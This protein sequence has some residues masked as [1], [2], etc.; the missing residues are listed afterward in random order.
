MKNKLFFIWLLLLSGLTMGTVVA[1]PA[2]STAYPVTQLDPRLHVE[3]Y[4]EK[5]DVV[6]GGFSQDFRMVFRNN[7]KDKLRV[8][9]E[10]YADLVCGQRV[11]NDWLKN[12]GYTMAPGELVNPTW[13]HKDFG[14]MRIHAD[15]YCP[16]ETWKKVGKDRHNSDLYNVISKLGYRIIKIENLS[17]SERAK[18]VERKKLEEER[19]AEA[20]RKAAEK[21]QALE[22]H[23]AETERKA[24][25][26]KKKEE[27]Q[28]KLA[29][30][31]K[32]QAA[33]EQIADAAKKPQ[34]KAPKTIE[35]GQDQQAV[36]DKKTENT[37]NVGSDRADVNN[38][39][40]PAKSTDQ[41]AQGTNGVLTAEQFEGGL[42]HVKEG[43][44]FKDSSGNFYRKENGMVHP[45]SKAMY[46]RAI[47]QE[48][49]EAIDQ[50][51]AQ[52]AEAKNIVNQA[53]ELFVSNFYAQGLANNLR[54]AGK[55]N[56]DY[57]NIDDLNEA[58]NQQLAAIRQQAAELQNTTVKNMQSY[59]TLMTTGNNAT[60][61]GVASAVGSAVAVLSSG[62]AERKAREELYRQRSEQEALIKEREFKALVS[63][64]NTISK[65]FSQGGMPLSSHRVNTPVVYLFAYSSNNDDW[66][67]NAQ[68][69]LKIS[70]VVPFHR[71][72]DGG[73]PY[74]TQV[75]QLFER[76]GMIHPT[77]VG[78]FTDKNEA[79]SYRKALL[80]LAPNARFVISEVEIDPQKSSPFSKMQESSSASDFW[81]IKSV[82]SG[83]DF[84]DKKSADAQAEQISNGNNPA[85]AKTAESVEMQHVPDTDPV[86][87]GG[88]K[89]FMKWLSDNYEAP[90]EAI[91][92]RVKGRISVSF[93]VDY[94][95]GLVDF[96]V[97]DDLGFGTG[98]ALADL[99]KNSPPWRPGHRQGRATR[100]GY[101]IP[102]NIDFTVL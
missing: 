88:F 29:A 90:K 26:Q 68:L 67:K 102:M 95:G 62:N 61:S 38:L 3:L 27:E 7:T 55:L 79:D 59:T 74:V 81:G 39:S 99:L 15:K 66:K 9:I 85:L 73:Y 2:A 28:Q 71:Q 4:Y 58:F 101:S 94:T 23:K 12:Q 40:S 75:N 45:V 20:E 91:K 80:E 17:E 22:Q 48:R 50:R 98:A 36:I 100:V 64:R 16:R 63:L 65:T 42:R 97:V 13:T 11:G 31:E 41:P 93:M 57:K 52:V 6:F 70:N 37:R 19:K 49:Q 69:P 83:A 8:Y 34:D 82:K 56:G 25:E 51:N 76:A 1:Q 5:S 60:Y 14:Y 53:Q 44:F 47:A 54:E 43:E 24:A 35:K 18:E 77:I 30:A 84:W 78:Y 46:D 96:K 21:Q 33:E 87:P 92:A 89:S 10:F 32:Q 86:P 72:S